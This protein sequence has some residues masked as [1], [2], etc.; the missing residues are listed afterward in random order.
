MSVAGTWRLTIATPI[1]KHSVILE[2]AEADGIV[3][4]IAKGDAETTP[5]IDPRSD[6]ERL[7]WRQS[8]TKP[9]RLNLTFDVAIDGD[10]LTGTA[11]AGRLPASTVTGTR[12][13]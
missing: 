2:L 7:T 10:S 11:R 12:V 13:A 5:L 6:G 4:G 1:G 8:I 9:M 3:A